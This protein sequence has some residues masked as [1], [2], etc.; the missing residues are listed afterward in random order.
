MNSATPAEAAASTATV[1]PP[2]GIRRFVMVTSGYPPGAT[3]GL[4]RGCERLARALAIRGFDVTVLTVAAP[5][6]PAETCNDTGV[7]V[8]RVLKPWSL[9]PLFGLSYI[10]QTALWLWRLRHRWD[11]AFCQQLYLHSVSAAVVAKRLGKMSG[12]LLVAADAYSDITRLLAMRGGSQL[13]KLALSA[14]GLFALSRRSRAELIAAGVEPSRIF[15][16]R[17]FV[18]TKA[19]APGID[20]PSD[21]F[22]F[23]G[24]FDRQK[25][26]PLLMDAFDRVRAVRP[27]ARL[28]LIGRGPDE[29]QVRERARAVS[30]GAVTVEKWTDDP[31]SAYRRAQAVVSASDAE[32]LSNVMIEAMACG[33]PFIATD[34][35]GARDILGD[36]GSWPE[37]LPL[38]SVQRGIG[39]LLV[40]RGDADALARAM[41]DVLESDALR[42]SLGQEAR[43][44]AVAGYSEE[45]SVNAFLANVSELA[46]RRGGRDRRG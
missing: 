4:E 20:A 31:A 34:V 19:F 13:L 8:L 12:S 27:D 35:S 15:S 37:P 3:A 25:N 2:P 42:T 45:I 9:G 16:Y 36:D 6:L 26:V 24:R 21:E 40:N 43:R 32:G 1:T 46:S 11:F 23:M 39:G 29:A 41:L 14:D 18:D 22:V 38:G 30:D 28:R 7:S 44:S 33:A 17:Y 5:D 10:V